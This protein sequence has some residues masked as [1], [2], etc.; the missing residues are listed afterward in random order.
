ME[1]IGH[2]KLKQPKRCELLKIN[3][4]YSKES[5]VSGDLGP[6]TW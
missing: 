4:V 1:H 3:I 6:D 2:L 5:R